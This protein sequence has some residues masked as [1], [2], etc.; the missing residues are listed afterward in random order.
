MKVNLDE[1]SYEGIIGTQSRG[2][3]AIKGSGFCSRVPRN[4]IAGAGC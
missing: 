3:G 4:D 1:L 2:R